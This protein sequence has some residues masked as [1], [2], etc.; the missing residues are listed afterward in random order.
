[1]ASLIAALAYIVAPYHI[2]NVFVRGALAELWGMALFPLVLYSITKLVKQATVTHTA[3]SAIS[4]AIFLATH[5]ITS[6][7][8]APFIIIFTIIQFIHHKKNTN[9]PK[10][11]L[12]AFVLAFGLSSF[13]VIPAFFETSLIQSERLTKDYFNV[14]I[15]FATIKQLLFDFYWGYGPSRSGPIDGLSF[16]IGLI[17]LITLV[18]SPILIIWQIKKYE[19]EKF[20]ISIFFLF[21]T[22]ASLF[23][24]HGRSWL[25]WKNLPLL[26]YAQFPWRFLALVAIG[27][28]FLIGLSFDSIN[29]R[30]KKIIF[31]VVI[32]LLIFP[33]FNHFR[34]RD[35]LPTTTDR[36]ILTGDSFVT[37]SAGGLLDYLPRTVKSPPIKFAPDNPT[38][39]TGGGNVQK[40]VKRSNYFASEI[41][42]YSTDA[43]VEFPVM[44]FPGWH[45]YINGQSKPV[46]ISTDNDLGL[47]TIKLGK[48]PQLVQAWF[49][50][51][52]IRQLANLLTFISAATLISWVVISN[53]RNPQK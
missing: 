29:F 7:L 38:T 15:H 30:Q 51:T 20:A 9:L 22:F 53:E 19:K 34:F 12:A 37:Q 40:F 47:I 46:D 28:S 23:M 16:F 17:P 31:S 4:L 35:Y 33:S 2:L 44:Y 8:C 21:L 32:A 5:N 18:F 24:T 27:T 3:G 11:L 14:F 13:F 6:L 45:V 52:P 26:S 50:N 36:D 10:Y 49:E 41:E 42:V 48:G 25:L 39:K 1:M 43:T